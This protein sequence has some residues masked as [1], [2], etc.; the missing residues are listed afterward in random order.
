MVQPPQLH[1]HATH[2]RRSKALR[3]AVTSALRSVRCIEAGNGT[4]AK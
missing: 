4:D 2:V 1:D 3:E